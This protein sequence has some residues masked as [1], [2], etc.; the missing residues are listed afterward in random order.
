[1]STF[2]IDPRRRMPPPWLWDPFQDPRW[3]AM[4]AATIALISVVGAWLIAPTMTTFMMDML[5][6]WAHEVGHFVA[7]AATG[8]AHGL[9]INPDGSGHAVVASKADI[10]VSAAGPLVPVWGGAL[11]V[12]FGATRTGNAMML[13]GIATAVGLSTYLYVGDPKVQAALW[14]WTA[15]F[16]AFAITPTPPVMRS[17]VVLIAG[18]VLLKGALDSLPYLTV[19]YIDGNLM[20]PSDSQSIADALDVTVP[21][22][23]TGLKMLM[24]GGCVLA[25]IY[26]VNWFA[27]R[28]P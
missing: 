4:V 23:A 26:T 14:G 16:A 27:R 6:T 1:M 13:A 19:G 25:L 20:H 5:A 17:A 24:V 8:T 11:L 21:D 18:M 9:T 12:A 10:I 2:S 7:G 22:V 28:R 15:L 3:Q